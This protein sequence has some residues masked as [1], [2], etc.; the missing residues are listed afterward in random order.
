MRDRIRR[1]F[2]RIEGLD[3]IVIK[4]HTTPHLDNSF[5]YVTGLKSGLFNQSMA[6]IDREGGLEV[7]TTVLVEDTVRDSKIPVTSYEQSVDLERIVTERLTDSRRIG[8]NSSELISE[9][10][11]M[12]NRLLKDTELVDVSDQMNKARAI[13]DSTEIETIRKACGIVSRVADRIP[14]FIDSDTTEHD[15][16]SFIPTSMLDGGADGPAFD[17]N[18]SF[19]PNSA[20]PH[21]HTG[22]VRIKPGDFILT[23]FGAEADRYVSDIT[24]T[25]FYGSVNE[26]QRRIYD[27]VLEAQ[28]NAI[29]MIE[30]G[31]AASDVHRTVN[32]VIDDAGYH[33]KFTHSTGHGIGLNV[34]DAALRVREES[35]FLLEEGMVFTVEPG[36]YV[37]GFGGVR[38][39]DDIVV[40]SDGCEEL[41]N[42]DKE[43][44]AI[45]I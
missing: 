11:L 19:G 8:F 42:A 21:Y 17:T 38:V 24:R 16:A 34:H 27:A 37:V 10:Y 44:S 6:L 28:R 4:N 15:V 14:E 18:C 3:T 13:K 12:F 45:D 31:I 2:E 26:E 23:D 25:W 36:I 32:K 1:I 9:D 43:L 33:G 41:T 39:E 20:L 29:D 7:I 22:N 30:P 35:D 5:F 40:T